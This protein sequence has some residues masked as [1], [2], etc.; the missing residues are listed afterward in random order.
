MAEL[1]GAPTSVEDLQRQP[2][3][4]GG[5]GRSWVPTPTSAAPLVVVV[6]VSCL[7]RASLAVQMAK[8]LRAVQ[9]TQIQSLAWADPLEKGMATHSSILA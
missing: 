5:G 8:R 6:S 2:Q 4:Q 1:S 7:C 3:T 9:E